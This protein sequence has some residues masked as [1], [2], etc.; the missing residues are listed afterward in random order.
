LNSLDTLQQLLSV[1]WLR[2]ETAMWRELDI[3]AMRKFLMV[4]PSLDLGC[5]D[6]VF[7]FIRAGGEFESSFDVFEDITDTRKYYEGRDIFDTF[8][9]KK[10]NFVKKVP[11]YKISVGF[12]HKENLLKKANQLGFYKNTTQGN[13]NTKLPFPDESF[14]SIFSNIVYWL[15]S[16]ELALH[17]I[18]RVLMPGGSACI[19][20]PN[21][22][23]VEYS[24]FENFYN[25]TKNQKWKFL[26]KID[27]NRFSENI[28]HAKSFEEWSKLVNDSGLKIERHTMH[29]S[30][31]IIQIWDIGMRPI[32]P[33]LLECM[34]SVGLEKKL[35]IKKD[36]IKTMIEFLEPLTNLDSELISSYGAGFHCFQL[37]K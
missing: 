6:G 34:N 3:Q 37:R 33:L 25:K 36:W 1:F 26:E 9:N 23:L 2:P 11:D 20:L 35:E 17:E 16:P 12:D 8:T 10:N 19:M 30:K 18:G 32:F 28:K 29:L 15:N 31:P 27:R 4:E 24:F 14:R 21:K 22:S 13:A 7:S 5:G